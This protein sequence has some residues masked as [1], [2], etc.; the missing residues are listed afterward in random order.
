MMDDLKEVTIKHI[1]PIQ[2]PE[3]EVSTTGGE[4]SGTNKKIC[5]STN[6]KVTT[7]KKKPARDFGFEKKKENKKKPK[8]R[9]KKR[10]KHKN[11]GKQ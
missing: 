1:D 4:V 2:A 9:L 6:E 7:W 11:T 5:N 10:H 8:K 3:T